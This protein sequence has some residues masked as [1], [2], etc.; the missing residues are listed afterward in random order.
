MLNRYQNFIFDLD[1]TLVNSSEEILLCLKKAFEKSNYFIDE[2]KFTSNVIGPPIKQI[3]NMLAP[4]LTDENLILDIVKKFRQIYD[5]DENDISIM[6][7]GLYE[8]LSDLKN[9]GK[10]LFIATFKPQIPTVRIVDKFK[11]KHFFDDIYTI[12]KFGKNITKDEMINDIIEKYGLERSQ[13]I[14]IGDAK[15]D[16]IAARQA[17]VKSIGVFW[18]YGKDKTELIK[19]AD[20]IIKDVKELTCQK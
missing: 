3:I 6:Y 1:G 9:K 11:I 13:T 2:Q 8:L 10:K 15:S 7:D 14:M 20:Y 12:D 18:G 19:N 4:E 16:A 17:G 5:Y